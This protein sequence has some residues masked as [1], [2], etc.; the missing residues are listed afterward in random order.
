MFLEDVRG[1][2]PLYREQ[3]EI[4]GQL[5]AASVVDVGTFLD[6]GAGDGILGRTIA[7]Q[8]PRARGV[9]LDFSESMIAAARRKNA[10]IE[11]RLEFVLEDF[12]RPRW[13]AAVGHRAPFDVIVSGFSIHHQADARKRRVY[14][15]VF[16]L[17]RP[18]GLF[19]NL[20]HVLPPSKRI[21][22]FFENMF[23]DSLYRFHQ[24]KGSELTRD[25]V[26]LDFY[27]R[28]DKAANILAPVEKQCQWLREIGYGDVDCYFKLFELALFGGRKPDA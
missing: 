10:D 25:R 27:N 5:I 23:V 17:L 19:L 26:A 11:S 21:E 8:F 13:T 16:R 1:G 6:L 14:E 3:L 4:M 9:A 22:S 28:N 24:R 20:E 7:L 12:G 15:E 18:G 2:I